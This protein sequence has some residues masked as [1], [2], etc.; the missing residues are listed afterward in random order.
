MSL[1]FES[2][3]LW[4]KFEELIGKVSSLLS[5]SYRDNSRLIV[6]AQELEDILATLCEDYNDREACKI[7]DIFYNVVGNPD[8]LDADIVDMA[9]QNFLVTLNEIEEE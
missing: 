8:D 4:N 1:S 5:E 2:E 9:L 3:K 7:L 6:F